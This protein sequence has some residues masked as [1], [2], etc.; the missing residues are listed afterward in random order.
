M[1]GKDS[2]IKEGAS[3][4]ACRKWRMFLDSHVLFL[5][6]AGL[7]EETSSA[8]RGK[9]EWV[10]E[11]STV[12]PVEPGKGPNPRTV[13][14]QSQNVLREKVARGLRKSLQG[15]SEHIRICE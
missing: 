14:I 13:Q 8:E 6:S 3:R 10:H 1:S 9:T 12:C 15:L 2:G 11:C 5:E 7:C 4:E